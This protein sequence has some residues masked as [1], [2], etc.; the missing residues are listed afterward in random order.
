MNA[1]QWTAMVVNVLNRFS[2]GRIPLTGADNDQTVCNRPGNSQ[3]SRQQCLVADAQHRLVR[4][5]A[6]APSA[7]E[8]E[9]SQILHVDIISEGAAGLG[10]AGLKRRGVRN[11]AVEFNGDNPAGLVKLQG[12][13]NVHDDVATEAGDGDKNP[14]LN[15]DGRWI[16][17][18]KRQCIVSA[19]V[20]GKYEAQ[21]GDV[22][23]LGQR[24]RGND[25]N[26]RVHFITLHLAFGFEANVILEAG[27]RIELATIYLECHIHAP[28]RAG[29]TSDCE[30]TKLPHSRQAGIYNSRLEYALTCNGSDGCCPVGNLVTDTWGN[31]HDTAPKGGAYGIGPGYVAE[32]I[33]DCDLPAIANPVAS[34][35]PVRAPQYLGA[36]SPRSPASKLSCYPFS[37]AGRHDVPDLCWST[38]FAITH[39]LRSL[40]GNMIWLILV[41]SSLTGG[42]YCQLPAA[43]PPLHQASFMSCDALDAAP[44][45]QSPG[46]TLKKQN[47]LPHFTLSGFSFSRSKSQ[48]PNDW[49]SHF[50]E[51]R[52]SATAQ[53]ISNPL[54]SSA[55]GSPELGARLWNQS[56]DNP[57][58]STTNPPEPKKKEKEQENSPTPTSGSPG[59]IFW[60]IPAFKVDYGK[61]GFKP[62]TVKEK[63]QEWAKG[64]Y[65]P[66]GLGAGAVEAATLE[67][68][69]TDGFC[70]YGE[71]WSGY[72]KCFGALE[73]DA[74][75]S[76]FIGDFALTSL[77][78]QDPR[79][80]RMGEGSFGR[81]L[82]YAV[83]RVFV[84]LNDSGHTVFY[85]SA[86]TGTV[87]AAGISNLYYPEK[88]RTA[89][90]TMSRIAI[91]FGNT[92]LY[93]AA[94][95][96]CPDIHSRLPWHPRIRPRNG[97]LP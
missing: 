68:S 4:A 10:S 63:F 36:P 14:I 64:A 13:R 40:G 28:G 71:G 27:I 77:W 2:V 66:L 56:Q 67:H 33:L 54:W 3:G 51:R 94:A 18:E 20:L 62:L 6:G 1:A 75:I 9:P 80:F 12:G 82:W 65:D 81:R 5:H 29:F 44:L 55:L 41:V 74:N 24:D 87:A 46:L 47:C 32:R 91:D 84:T 22:A 90:H 92:A 97:Q 79:Y 86:I 16:A 39:R 96:F 49:R 48:S 89:G 35:G 50:G 69:S 76:S 85:S 83:T 53:P 8:N 78:H 30:D 61:G 70:G 45:R 26:S 59:H 73:L 11:T 43:A 88:D 72:G 23:G 57:P 21:V 58:Q 19:A 7:R 15:T 38:S 17:L 42:L 25:R 34:H 93:N 37:A 31:L 95:E 52:L 60:V